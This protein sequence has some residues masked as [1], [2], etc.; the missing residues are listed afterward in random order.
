MQEP[1]AGK[2]DSTKPENRFQAAAAEAPVLTNGVPGCGR[3]LEYSISVCFC[4]AKQ[5][6]KF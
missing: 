5:E 1:R 4:N 6:N 2:T 3:L